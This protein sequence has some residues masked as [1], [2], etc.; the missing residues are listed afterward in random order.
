MQDYYNIIIS[1]ET[2]KGDLSVINYSGTPVGVYSAM[3]QVVS[4]G[5]NGSS[6]LSGLTIPILFRQ[7]AVDAGYYSPFDGAVLQKNVVANFLFSA[8]TGSPY[9]YYVYNTSDEFQKF[10]DLSAYIIDWGDGSPKQSI[11]TYSPN[12]IM[13]TYAAEVNTYTITLEQTNPWGVTKV[14]KTISTPYE[15][16]TIYN[17]TGQAY[18]APSYGNWIGTPVSYDYI[19]SGDAVNVVSAQT[20]NNYVSV[21]FTISGITKSRIN[22]LKPYGN[23]TLDQRLN[24]PIISYGQIW[25]SITDYNTVYTAYTITGIYY[26]DYSDGTTIFFEQSSGLTSEN[27]VATAITKN[28]VLLKA[29]DQ[30]QIQTDVFVE[31]GKNSAYERVQRLGEVDNLGDMI[32]YGYGFFNVVYRDK[33]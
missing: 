25:G 7:S 4:S 5:P 15:N 33:V 24:L 28:E 20:S 16:V 12:S 22:E 3:T 13:H 1:P 8:T 32:N 31:R 21:P 6:L 14:S 26:Y 2:I 11:T 30:P 29:V 27:L 23:L 19:F 9:N 17:P 10:L 18:F